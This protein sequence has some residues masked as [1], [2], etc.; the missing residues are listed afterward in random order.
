LPLYPYRCTTCGY[1]FE[2]IQSFSA[3]P[4]KLCPKCGNATLERP[5]T[6]PRFQFKGA[7]WYINDYAPK[8]SEGSSDAA[9]ETKPSESKEAPKSSDA[10]G[11]TAAPSA[12]ASPAPA[13]APAST[14]KSSE[15]S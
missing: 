11:G 1:R 12:P 4:E 13:S 10:T 15:G 8:S 6:A 2:K 3:E 7:G 5:L 9:T 14:P